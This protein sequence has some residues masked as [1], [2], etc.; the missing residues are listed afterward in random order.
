MKKYKKISIGIDQSYDRTG[1]AISVDGKLKVIES[2]DFKGCKCNT[3]KRLYLEKKLIPIIKSCKNKADFVI[4]LVE[5][6]RTFSQGKRRSQGYGL[7]P[8]YLIKTGALIGKICE[9]AYKLD[10]DVFSVDTRVW[11]KA[12]LGTAKSM[13]EMYSEYG[14]PEKGMAIEFIQGL[15]FDTYDRNDKGEI[16]RYERGKNVGKLKHDDDKCDAGCIS[17]YLFK[18]KEYKW[19]KET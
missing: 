14:K 1:I 15:N 18:A 19:Q 17:L 4:V 3:E 10:I 9:V 5:K 2:I 13:S 16:K 8:G 6:I 11:R 12:V 7:R